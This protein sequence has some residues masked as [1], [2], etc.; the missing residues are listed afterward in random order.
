MRDAQ[1]R[2]CNHDILCKS[3]SR[4]HQ[5]ATQQMQRGLFRRVERLAERLSHMRT[6]QAAVVALLIAARYDLK[7][8]E[9]WSG[10]SKDRTDLLLE[11]LE[12]GKLMDVLVSGRARQARSDADTGTADNPR[13]GATGGTPSWLCQNRDVQEW[14]TLLR[15]SSSASRP[16]GGG[17]TSELCLP[18]STN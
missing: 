17:R 5:R 6:V 4:C 8:D 13:C 3:G 2:H 1:A 7:A 15:L 18:M 14:S 11:H 12:I 16:G 10:F 9:Y